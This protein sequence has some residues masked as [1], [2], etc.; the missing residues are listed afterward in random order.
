ME[1]KSEDQVQAFTAS[2]KEMLAESN[3]EILKKF[4]IRTKINSVLERYNWMDEPI[5]R[6]KALIESGEA[7]KMPGYAYWRLTSESLM[8]D[9]F[10][11]L[12]CDPR[13]LAGIAKENFIHFSGEVWTSKEILKECYYRLLAYLG[14]L[15]PYLHDLCIVQSRD[16]DELICEKLPF[17]DFDNF[18]TDND[19]LK[20][21]K[22]PGNGRALNYRE[23]KWLKTKKE[24]F[25]RKRICNGKNYPPSGFYNDADGNVVGIYFGDSK[26]EISEDPSILETWL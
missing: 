23:W 4:D 16:F 13:I 22:I 5:T 12:G 17:Q 9:H 15:S 11:V 26:V 10:R 1:K 7:A 2:L 25:S 6:I 8:G 14:N 24:E 21:V 3:L 19:I 20:E 18:H